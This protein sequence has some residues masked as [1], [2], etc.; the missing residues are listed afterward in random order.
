MQILGFFWPTMPLDFFLGPW[1]ALLNIPSNALIYPLPNCIAAF[2]CNLKQS[3]QYTLHFYVKCSCQFCRVK[4]SVGD[5]S[6]LMDASWL[7]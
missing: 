4:G 1:R 6:S 3:A 5:M 2:F 7:A